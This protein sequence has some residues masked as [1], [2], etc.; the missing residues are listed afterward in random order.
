MKPDRTK[1]WENQITVQTGP[2]LQLLWS[3]VLTGFRLQYSQKFKKLVQI[4]CINNC[5]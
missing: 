5:L 3:S 4:S 1:P 2:F